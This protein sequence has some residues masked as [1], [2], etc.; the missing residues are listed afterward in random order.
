MGFFDFLSS[1]EPIFKYKIYISDDEM[2]VE[3]EGETDDP[4][5][6]GLFWAYYW[7]KIMYNLGFPIEYH[8]VDAF[9]ALFKLANE[10]FKSSTKFLNKS[11]E[12]Y[13][14]NPKLDIAGIE[15]F[16]SGEYLKKGENRVIQTHF[17]RE[18]NEEEVYLSGFALLE[19]CLNKMIKESKFE[20][21]TCAKFFENISM[22]MLG[23]YNKATSNK[24]GVGGLE[25]TILV[26]ENA[27]Q[28]A[29]E[30]TDDIN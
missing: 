1:N 7:A 18:I 9:K 29:V 30:H 17:P 6:Y 8:G 21:E 28:I 22:A 24:A 15:D 10:G 26:P 13:K 4:K 19:H 12:L 3:V 20:K 23:M 27:F 16:Y 11:N 5:E 14:Y 2:R 25:G